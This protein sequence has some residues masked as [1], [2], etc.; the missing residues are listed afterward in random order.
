MGTSLIPLVVWAVLVCA[1]MIT[2]RDQVNSAGVYS[3]SLNLIINDD[4]ESGLGQ[5]ND[6][7]CKT[8]SI[9]SFNIMYPN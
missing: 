4:L 5:A 9:Y 6:I 2:S 1:V 8:I 3:V 7:R